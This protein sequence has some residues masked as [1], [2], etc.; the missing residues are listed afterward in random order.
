MAV[1]ISRRATLTRYLEIMAAVRRL[2]NET[3]F[4]NGQQTV[5]AHQTPNPLAID[6]PALRS[7]CAGDSTITVLAALE[8][9]SLNGIAEP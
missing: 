5:L 2:G 7:Q 6:F 9:R 8:C 4:A 3:A 1:G